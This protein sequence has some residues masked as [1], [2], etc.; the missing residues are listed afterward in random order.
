LTAVSIALP[1][2]SPA[3]SIPATDSAFRSAGW[4]GPDSAIAESGLDAPP[5]GRPTVRQPAEKALV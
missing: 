4:L 5:A 1:A 3:T 2:G